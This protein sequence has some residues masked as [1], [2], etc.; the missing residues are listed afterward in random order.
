[1]FEVPCC[2]YLLQFS[3]KPGV[4]ILCDVVCDFQVSVVVLK[5]FFLHFNEIIE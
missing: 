5:V 4:L 1:V 3:L 2:L